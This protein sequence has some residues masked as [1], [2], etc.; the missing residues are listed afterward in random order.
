MSG[1]VLPGAR[2]PARPPRGTPDRADDDYLASD[3]SSPVA[4]SPFAD[5]PP[6]PMS[7]TGSPSTSEDTEPR[8]RR[9]S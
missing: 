3:L 7:P 5:D 8:R 4:Y 9:R 6:N 1:G 2:P